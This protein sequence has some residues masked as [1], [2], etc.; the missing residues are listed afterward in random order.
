[1]EPWFHPNLSGHEAENLL[2]NKVTGSFLFRPSKSSPSDCTLSIKTDN[3]ITHVRAKKTD[4]GYF[5]FPDEVFPSLKS[6]IAHYIDHPLTEKDGTL[7]RL[8]A[9]V[10]RNETI[11]GSWFHGIMRE[12][13]AEAL[14]ISKG[15]KG[16]F[17]V[18][19]SD[20]SPEGYTLSV[21]TDEGKVLHVPVLCKQL[22]FS[23]DGST[24]YSTLDDLVN[25]Y[26][27]SPFTY[28]DQTLS[29][30]EPLRITFSLLRIDRLIHELEKPNKQ[31]PSKTGFAFEFQ[32]I[33]DQSSSLYSQKEGKRIET[34]HKN[35]YKDIIPFDHTLVKLKEPDTYGSTYINAS[36]ISTGK[37]QGLYY[38]AT[39]GP[40]DATIIDFWKM[41]WQERSCVIVMLTE[42]VEQGEQ[43]CCQYWPS[44][45]ELE[46]LHGQIHISSLE[47][48]IHDHYTLRHFL[49]V[50][51]DH[52]D[53][54][55]HVFHYH[56]RDWPLGSVPRDTGPFLEYWQEID[57]KIKETKSGPVVVHCNDGVGRTGAFI[58]I[59]SLLRNGEA[60]GLDREVDVKR[61]VQLLQR[62]RPGMVQNDAQYRFIY[63]A[64]SQYVHEYHS[65]FNRSGSLSVVESLL[66]KEEEKKS[67]PLLKNFYRRLST[68]EKRKRT[69]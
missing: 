43:S 23:I 36:Y 44:T 12:R 2:Q 65:S 1:M 32:Q 19:E 6:L 51:E 30:I 11:S 62:Q 4:H 60:K 58:C 66:K 40:L 50:H 48:T 13:E 31:L 25:H 46:V 37:D 5:L 54:E 18:R 28:N 7:V 38:I 3:V 14:L 63:L 61:N 42:Q 9:P 45:A 21:K 22:R 55:R 39:Q 33:E 24:G 29:L 17:L 64:L 10:H 15:V 27:D 20:D 26:K 52:E 16:S 49:L 68:S 59:D 34:M 53:E 56:F 41:I 67:S 8:M 47:E 69:Q 57:A 35:R